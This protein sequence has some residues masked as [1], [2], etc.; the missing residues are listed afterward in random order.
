MQLWPANENAFAASFAAVSRRRVG[1]DDRRRRVAE[2]E[3]H[4]LAVRALGRAPQPTPPEPVNVISFTRSSATSSS[5]IARR[6][7]GDDVQPARRA[8]PPPRSSSA[9]KSAESG[10]AAAGLSTT[11]QPA[12]SAGAI[13]CAT[14]LSGKLNGEIAPTIPIGSRSVKRELALAGRRRVHRHDL[15]GELAR[16]DRGERV[17]R[18]GPLRLDPRRFHRLARP[19]RRSSAPPRRARSASRRRPYRGSERARA[20]GAGSSSAAAAA[21]SARRASAAPPWRP[22]RR[23]RRSTASGRPSS[24]RSRRARPPISSGWSIDVVATVQL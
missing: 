7:A 18:D 23:A 14:R 2:L 16:L 21:S 4:A 1:A 11:G 15:A 9:R 12:A 20:R 24:R 13:L 22:G 6:G 17:R 19:R 5:P 8:G 3:L 10:V